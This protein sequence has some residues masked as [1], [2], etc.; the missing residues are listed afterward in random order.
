[1]PCQLV[2][3]SFVLA[4]WWKWKSLSHVW[5]HGLHSPCNSPGQNTGVGSLSLLQGVFPIQGLNPGLPH[6]KRILYWLSHQ[7]DPRLLEWVAY[8]FSKGSSQP[9]NRTQ[10]SCIAGGFFTSWATREAPFHGKWRWNSL[11]WLLTTVQKI[12]SLKAIDLIRWA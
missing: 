12:S 6:C 1:M 4:A 2:R 3:S 7:G 10:V 9:R 11:S 5:P 8:L